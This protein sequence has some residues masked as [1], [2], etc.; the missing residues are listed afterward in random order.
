MGYRATV[1]E[2]AGQLMEKGYDV[3]FFG[4]HPKDAPVMHDILARMRQSGVQIPD[5]AQL[6]FNEQ[7]VAEVVDVVAQ[8]NYVVATRFH[9]AVLPLAMGIPTIGVAYDPKTPALLTQMGQGQYNVEFG[10]ASVTTLQNRFAE[11]VA[12]EAPIRAELRERTKHQR[13][14]MDEQYDRIA[15][16]VAGPVNPPLASAGVRRN[17][18]E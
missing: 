11:L 16:M 2:F 3:F 15:R 18:A 14:A 9:A 10:E 1:A 17:G 6:A 12:N 7:T 5:D 4:M 8:A 13:A